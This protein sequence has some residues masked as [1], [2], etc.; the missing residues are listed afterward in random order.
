MGKNQ[1][2]GGK[3]FRR[4]YDDDNDKK[5]YS[6]WGKENNMKNQMPTIGQSVGTVS[7]MTDE[8]LECVECGEKYTIT[9]NQKAWFIEKGF[10]IPKRCDKCRKAKKEKHVAPSS[11]LIKR[12]DQLIAGMNNEGNSYEITFNDGTTKSLVDREYIINSL[13]GVKK[14]I[15]ESNV[16]FV[17]RA[18]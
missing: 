9:A 8:V 11:D 15:N 10:V 16:H 1:K 7:N 6:G 14:I 18:N 2:H 17:K 3:S 5:F 12:I 4:D 13:E